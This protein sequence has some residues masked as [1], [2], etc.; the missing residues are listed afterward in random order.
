MYGSDLAQDSRRGPRNNV[1]YSYLFSGA[2]PGGV[3]WVASHPPL[4]GRLSLQLRKGTKLSLRRF[5]L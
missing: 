1:T 3:D 2:D 5:C 4:W